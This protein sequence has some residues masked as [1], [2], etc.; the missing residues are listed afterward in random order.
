MSRKIDLFKSPIVKECSYEP[1]VVGINAARI[2][3]PLIDALNAFVGSGPNSIFDETFFNDIVRGYNN[4]SNDLFLKDFVPNTKATTD[5]IFVMNNFIHH[6]MLSEY[7]FS[8]PEYR[9]NSRNFGLITETFTNGEHTKKPISFGIIYWEYVDIDGEYSAVWHIDVT[10]NHNLGKKRFNLRT[11][12]RQIK[13]GDVIWKEAFYMIGSNE[14]RFWCETH[15]RV[16]PHSS[17]VAKLIDAIFRNY[18][19]MFDL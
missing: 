8:D 13:L 18:V 6:K 14:C 10:V 1:L 5:T 3:I 12:S 15:S 16:T 11:G 19:R 17:D 7:S 2:G 4:S 9:E